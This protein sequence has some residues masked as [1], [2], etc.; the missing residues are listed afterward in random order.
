L[1]KGKF[2]AT[3]HKC[4]MI[5]AR[6][7]SVEK[8]RV[9]AEKKTIEAEKVVEAEGKATKVVNALKV[10]EAELGEIRENL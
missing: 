4:S 2:R 9:E 6:V 8:K 5:S 10:S 3:E 7:D 1:H